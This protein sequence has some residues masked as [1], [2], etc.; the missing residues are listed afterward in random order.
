MEDKLFNVLLDLVCPYFIEN[1]HIDAHQ[2]Y[3]PDI[4]CVSVS[5]PGFGIG[6]SG[7]GSQAIE[8]KGIQTGREKVK[9][10]LFVEDTILRLEN[11]IVSTQ[12]LLKLINNFSKLSGYKINVQKSLAFLFINNGQPENQ[13]AN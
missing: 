4:L 11:P 8:I 5:L 10:S 2:R 9:L 1:F 12:K 6:S 7:Q 13:I 3:W